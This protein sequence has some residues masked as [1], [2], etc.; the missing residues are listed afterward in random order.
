M[1]GR[2]RLARRR[3]GCR[4]ANRRGVALVLA[5]W[6]LVVLSFVGLEMRVFSRADTGSARTLKEQVQ[7]RYLARGGVERGLALL[8]GYFRNHPDNAL[9]AKMLGRPRTGAEPAP[10]LL[11]YLA[12]R[13]GESAPLGAG[14]YR[15]RFEDLSARVNVNR[16]DPELLVNL[17]Q[18]TGLDLGSAQDVA[19]A[20]LDWI[21]GDDL[22]RP[23]GAERD[24]YETRGLPPPRNAAVFRLAELLRVKGM[25]REILY[26]GG[27]YKGLVRFL[28]T[29]GS[30]RVNVNS[31]PIEVLLSIPGM[32]AGTAAQLLAAR[33]RRQLGSLQEA[34]GR[35][36]IARMGASPLMGLLSFRT[37]EMAIEAEG[38]LTG[39]RTTSRVRAL[40]GVLPGGILVRGWEDDRTTRLP[41]APAEGPDSDGRQAN[42]IATGR[43]AR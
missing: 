21:D 28:T 43:T 32:D 39:S 42:A 2:S 8:S 30:G 22:H 29:E 4:L 27:R 35:D 31:A 9:M 26:G 7:A 5:L 6:V 3:N 38:Y 34:L 14:G 12:R 25:T 18:Q 13:A 36:A 11:A 17:A 41:L 23:R 16:T 19:D 15:L 24:W 40:V 37:A 33:E 10:P 20:I 1:R